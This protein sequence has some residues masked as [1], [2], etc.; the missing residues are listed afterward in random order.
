MI[1]VHINDQVCESEEGSTII[2]VAD[3]YGIHIPRFC[4]HSELSISANCRMCLVEVSNSSKPV[5]ACAT[6]VFEGLQIFT[7]SAKTKEAQESVL[8]F[9]L[10]NHPLDCP[11]CDQG[12]EC[13]LQDLTVGYGGD[14]SHYHEEKRQVQNLQLG[15][16]VATEMNRCIHCT[17]CVRFGTEIAG[18]REIGAI[19]RGEDTRIA[20]A[21]HQ[22]LRSSVSGNIIDLCPVGALTSKPHRYQG[23]TW[24][25][26]AMPALSYHDPGRSRLMAHVFRG[27]IRRMTSRASSAEPDYWI[28][29]RDRFG[30]LGMKSDRFSK[31]MMWSQDAWHE[32]SMTELYEQMNALQQTLQRWGAWVHP[33]SSQ[34]DKVVLQNAMHAFR[35]SQGVFDLA[36]RQCQLLDRQECDWSQMQNILIMGSFWESHHPIV[37]VGL[38]QWADYYSHT[39]NHITF[40]KEDLGIATLSQTVAPLSQW[41]TVLENWIEHAEQEH[42]LV[43]INVQV[44]NVASETIDALGQIL[45]AH[46]IAYCLIGLE[47]PLKE[48]DTAFRMRSCG[49]I[50]GLMTLHMEAEDWTQD[51]VMCQ[52]IQQAQAYVSFSAVL[53]KSGAKEGQICIP[54]AA[55]LEYSGSYESLWSSD[56]LHVETLVAPPA[57]VLSFEDTMQSWLNQTGESAWTQEVTMEC[58]SSQSEESACFVC[59]EPV[60]AF[61]GKTL[62]ILKNP[63]SL[64]MILRRSKPLQE[65]PTALEQRGFWVSE[66]CL[67]STCHSIVIRDEYGQEYR[68]H[69]LVCSD[70]PPG[71]VLYWSGLKT[72]EP[73]FGTQCHIIEEI[74]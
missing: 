62:I 55:P 11:V 33:M 17:R 41:A 44:L 48:S 28:S 56:L 58:P 14:H 74:A 12:G 51:W 63:M 52:A 4:Y 31:P 27:T 38:R 68:D 10:V 40:V 37:L 60:E 54:I 71:T 36:H 70:L 66:D 50:D 21:L 47:A 69:A 26:Q 22:N 16:L 73:C 59:R 2:E 18:L 6:P 32:L 43:L 34:Q 23:R 39:L 46:N 25:Y 35:E 49:A 67:R 13:E 53:P 15:P 65:T 61:H 72:C 57:G 7:K 5:P 3:R 20:N 45:Q 1:N 8:E 30:F 64:N 24:Q 42:S 29:D 19:G 9:L